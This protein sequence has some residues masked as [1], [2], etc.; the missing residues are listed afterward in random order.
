[1]NLIFVYYCSKI[2]NVLINQEAIVTAF[3]Q[4]HE[5]ANDTQTELHQVHCSLLHDILLS[6]LYL[7][8]PFC[9]QVVGV[10]AAVE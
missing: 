9:K 4:A 7:K 1:M 3:H 6:V 10:Q 5:D 8:Q 2:N